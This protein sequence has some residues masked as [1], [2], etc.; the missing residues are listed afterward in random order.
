CFKTIY[1][2]ATNIAVSKGIRHIVTGLSRGQFFETRL[3]AE[4]F[5]NR[6]FDPAKIDA[7][8]LEARK[9]YHQREDAVSAHLAVD[10]LR[11]DTTLNEVQFV[12]FY[13]Y[14]DV[15]LHELYA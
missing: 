9:A 6:D 14:W 10:V 12:D 8:V 4:V 2:L 13:R 1:T 3:T 5:Q 15:P 11:D 7:L